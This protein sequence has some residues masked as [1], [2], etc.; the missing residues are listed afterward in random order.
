VTLGLW[1]PH[2]WPSR[3]LLPNPPL[4]ILISEMKFTV[5]LSVS[6]V[7]MNSGFQIDSCV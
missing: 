3:L 4:E 2:P 7:Q 5:P 6:F 1:S